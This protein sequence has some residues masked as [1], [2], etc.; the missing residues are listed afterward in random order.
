MAVLEEA[1]ALRER[2][3]DGARQQDRANRLIAA[4]QA[5]GDGHEIGR[6]AVLRAGMQRAGAPHAAHHLVEDQQHAVLVADGADRSDE[7]TSALQS[8]LRNSYAVCFL[9]KETTTFISI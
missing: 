6:D 1:G 2:V 8:L 7:H 4:A 3:E 9:T 5:L